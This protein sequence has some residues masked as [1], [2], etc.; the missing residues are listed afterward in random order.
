MKKRRWAALALCLLLVLRTAVP[1]AAAA[2]EN[3]YFTAVAGNVLPL[4]DSTMPFW[5][6]GYLYIPASIFTG[7]IRQY[8]GITYNYNPASQTAVLYNG[9]GDHSL[10]FYLNENY[11]LDREG[12]VSYPGGLLRNGI[13][14][15]PAYLVARYFNLSYSVLEVKHGHL[16]WLR[17]PGFDL[18]EKNFVNAAAYPMAARYNDYMKSKQEMQPPPEEPSGESEGE[19]ISVKAA[20]LCLKADG[21]TSAMLDALDYYDAQAAFFCT[22]DFLETQGGLLRRMTATGHS[23]GILA[24]AANSEYTVSEQLEAGR[25]ALERATCGGTRLAMIQNG[26][27]EA[28][29]EAQAAGYRCVEPDLDRSKYELKSSSNALS[30]LKKLSASRNSLTVWLADSATPAGLRAFLSA[31]EDADGRC[32]ALTE[33]S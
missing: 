17:L 13:P 24:D 16:V 19:E 1:A 3:V 30:L 28:L 8:F 4:S 32:L 22:P 7:S 26:K 10:I 23:I 6:G 2:E 25:R 31:I 27:N 20:Y 15:V 29:Q 18:P 5:N 14:Y 11:T 21:N 12:N 33:T 9:M